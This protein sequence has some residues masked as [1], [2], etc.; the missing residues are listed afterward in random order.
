[1]TLTIKASDSV[2]SIINAVNDMLPSDCSNSDRVYDCYTIID[3]VH[4]N[5]R[6]HVAQR[7]ADFKWWLTVSFHQPA[8]CLRFEYGGPY[9]DP[10][11]PLKVEPRAIEFR[12][13]GGLGLNLISQLSDKIDYTYQSGLNTLTVEVN[14]IENSKEEDTCL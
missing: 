14:I 11:K 7:D 8:V 2:S 10:T 13:I 4:A 1:M 3:E 12:P 9:F 6:E 5:M